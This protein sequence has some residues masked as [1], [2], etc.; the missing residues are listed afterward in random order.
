MI[1]GLGVIAGYAFRHSQTGNG[2]QEAVC[3]GLIGLLA[4]GVA[5]ALVVNKMV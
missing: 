2:E 1:F 3:W 4:T 5:I